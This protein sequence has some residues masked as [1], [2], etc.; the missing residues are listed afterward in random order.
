MQRERPARVEYEKGAANLAARALPQ[1]PTVR[2]ASTNEGWFETVLPAMKRTRLAPSVVLTV[3]EDVSVLN[4]PGDDGSD[5]ETRLLAE[6]ILELRQSVQEKREE[7]PPRLGKRETVQKWRRMAAD[8]S[9][10]RI[11]LAVDMIQDRPQSAQDTFTNLNVFIHQADEKGVLKFMDA[12]RMSGLNKVQTILGAEMRVTATYSL[13]LVVPD[14][15]KTFQF[16]AS[17]RLISGFIKEAFEGD[18][19]AKFTDPEEGPKKSRQGDPP[20]MTTEIVDVVDVPGRE[21]TTFRGIRIKVRKLKLRGERDPKDPLVGHMA[22]RLRSSRLKGAARRVVEATT[23]FLFKM[24][25]GPRGLPLTIVIYH[26]NDRRSPASLVPVQPVEG[27][28]SGGGPGEEIEYVAYY[29]FLH[30]VAAASFYGREFDY[31]NHVRRLADRFH[32]L[33]VERTATLDIISQ[34]VPRVE[35]EPTKFLQY[36]ATSH[37][38]IVRVPKDTPVPRIS[39]PASLGLD[40]IAEALQDV[41]PDEANLIGMAYL[42]AS[43]RRQ[44][45]PMNDPPDQLSLEDLNLIWPPQVEGEEQP[46]VDTDLTIKEG[47]EWM[48]E[49]MHNLSAEPEYFEQQSPSAF[50]S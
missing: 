36:L 11:W 18:Q 21:G 28:V 1:D 16:S 50:S 3:A 41:N 10:E 34:R 17:N 2:A 7:A 22:I 29:D 27:F 25:E 26:N 47:Q 43:L 48:D 9:M 38:Y 20:V 5:V 45:D 32:F 8:R 23:Y 39:L 4:L 33:T 37:S 12:P 46:A 40:P 30:L 49:Q 24:P 44:D 6:R 31:G 19:K 35:K 15:P 14:A 42:T 13:Q